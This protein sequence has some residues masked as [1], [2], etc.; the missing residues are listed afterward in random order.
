[1]SRRGARRFGVMSDFDPINM[2]CSIEVEFDELNDNP[3][4]GCDQLISCLSRRGS[5]KKI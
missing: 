4:F 3:K 1:M 5:D 2:K